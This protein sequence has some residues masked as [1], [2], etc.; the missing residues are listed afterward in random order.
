MWGKG[1]LKLSKNSMEHLMMYLYGSGNPIYDNDKS[2]HKPTIF[3]VSENGRWSYYQYCPYSQCLDADQPRAIKICENGSR[4][5]PCFVMAL[6][7]RIVWKNGY[8]KLRIKKSLLKNPTEVARAIKDAGFY[9]GDIF[10]LAGIDYETGQTTDKKIIKKTD[11]KIKEPKLSND[12]ISQLKELKKLLDE[13][14]IT[15]EE[16]KKLKEKILN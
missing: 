4:G 6:K 1:E 13:G 5:S 3:V 7:R 2:K 9:D 10:E 8:K 12:M 14:V 15:N 16:F 11:T